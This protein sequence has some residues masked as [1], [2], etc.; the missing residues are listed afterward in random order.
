ML[1]YLTALFV[2]EEKSASVWPYLEMTWLL[3]CAGTATAS[4]KLCF[5]SFHFNNEWSFLCDSWAFFVLLTKRPGLLDGFC[6]LCFQA[7]SDDL[8]EC[9]VVYSSYHIRYSEHW[10]SAMWSGECYVCLRRSNVCR[11][12]YYVI[13]TVKRCTPVLGLRQTY[14]SSTACSDAATRSQL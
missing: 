12:G 4:N 6:F 1:Q 11:C 2:F 13:R 10:W 8:E 3:Y 5:P 7:I 9:V 14:S